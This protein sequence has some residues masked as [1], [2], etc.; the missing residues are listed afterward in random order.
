LIV[1]FD[2]FWKHWL[3]NAERF[4]SVETTV[5]HVFSQ[6]FFQHAAE[7][8]TKPTLGRQE[9][10]ARPR[11]LMTRLFRPFAVATAFPSPA[12]CMAVLPE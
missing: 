2:I 7:A 8:P 10:R 1:F 12:T 11:R 4:A 9:S 5:V 3:C 6:I